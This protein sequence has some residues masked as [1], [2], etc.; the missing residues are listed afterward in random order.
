[1]SVNL[2]LAI[3]AIE[4]RL[5]VVGKKIETCAVHGSFVSVISSRL[6][7]PSTCPECSLE[8]SEKARTEA[9]EAERAAALVAKMEAKVG[10][11]LIPKR[12]Q[13]RTFETYQA[14]TEAQRKN[15]EKCREYAAL[16]E[17]NHKEGNSLLL[18]GKPGTGKTHLAA[19][20]AIKVME[21]KHTA[22]YR[23][24]S[25]ILQLVKGS[26]GDSDYSESEAFA[27]LVKPSLLI[28]D[29]VGATKPTEFEKAVLFEVINRRYEE[30]LPTI[31]ISNLMPKELS[32]AMGERCID[33]LREG[34]TAAVFDWASMRGQAQ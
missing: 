28:I 26:Y 6:D 25:G 5:G 10:G 2:S 8:R 16:F 9:V 31:V 21:G 17:Q 32:E 29:E 14:T 19:A 11:A 18:L 7:E 34:G 4:Q 27:S 23:T 22:L 3:S 20:I 12:F 13:T 33:R 1:V 30:M 24:V 15:L